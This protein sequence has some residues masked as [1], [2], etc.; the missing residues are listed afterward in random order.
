MLDPFGVLEEE[1]PEFDAEAVD[2]A[3]EM[4]PATFWAF[5]AC[6]VLSQAGLLAVSL[7]LLFGWFRGRWT[8]GWML[9]SGG[10]A[11]LV[12]TVAIYYWYRSTT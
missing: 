3:T 7:G 11:A 2:A 6:A 8:L 12:I 1:D 4:R 9:V 5:L 10:T